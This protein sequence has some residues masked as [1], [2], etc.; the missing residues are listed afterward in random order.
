AKKG[1]EVNS[2]A[3]IANA[4]HHRSDA[5]SSIGTFLGIAGAM[6]LGEDWRILDPAAAIVVSLFIIKSGYDIMKPSID[7]LLEA[8]LPEEQEAEITRIVT[9]IPGIKNIHNLRTRRIGNEIAVDLHAKMDGNLSLSAAHAIATLAEKAIK[10]RF[11]ENSFI[12][13]H[14]EPII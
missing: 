11:G 5:I 12:N 9:A 14:M 2:Q 13:I 1:R 3:V 4:W 10:Q 8:S 7:E 6:F